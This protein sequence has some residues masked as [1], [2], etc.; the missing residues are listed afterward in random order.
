[1]GAWF[2]GA[3][4][5]ELVYQAEDVM[6][7]WPADCDEV[8][9][10]FWVAFLKGR[11]RWNDEF[12]AA[13]STDHLFFDGGGSICQDEPKVGWEANGCTMK[14]YVRHLP[15]TLATFR[16]LRPL[17]DFPAV[18]G[19]GGFCRR[20]ILTPKTVA[21]SMPIMERLL[22]GTESLRQELERDLQRTFNA[23][24]HGFSARKCGCLSGKMYGDCCGKS[25]ETPAHREMRKAATE[26][27]DSQAADHQ[28]TER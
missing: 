15:F 3:K 24:T 10:D 26:Q 23:T 11:G 2:V 19:F 14:T 7:S 6:K 20:Y 13:Q 21:E 25:I 12:M 1:M 4:L 9:K 28:T 17:E 18:T 16:D 22:K 27:R 5:L 8:G